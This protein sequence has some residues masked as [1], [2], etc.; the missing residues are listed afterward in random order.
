MLGFCLCLFALSAVAGDNNLVIWDN[1]EAGDKWD[2]AYPVGNGRLGAMP[3]GNFPKEKILLNEETIWHRGAPKVM[4]E[5]SFQHLETVRRLE[6]AGD[7]AGADKSFEK[8]FQQGG[9]NP[10][11]YQP[12]GWLEIEYVTASPLRKRYRELDLK[13][14]IAKNV[15]TL[16]NGS[17]ITQNVFACGSD[18]VIAITIATDGK[19]TIRVRMDG[20]SVTNNQIMVACGGR[21]AVID[22]KAN[23]A[24]AW[25]KNDGWGHS[26][27]LLPDD[28]VA[29]VS[30]GGNNG[31]AAFLFDIKGEAA[32]DPYKQKGKRFQFDMPHGLHWDSGA[33]KL[34]VVDTPGLHLCKAGR[35]KKGELLLEVEKTWA[36]KDLGVIHGHDL[37]PVPCTSQIVMTTHEKVLFFD[38]KKGEWLK[39]KFI[40]RQDVK[41]F[42]PAADGKTFLVSV[43][44]T[45]WWTDT[46][47]I[48]DEKGGFRKLRTF[49]GAK[50]YKARWCPPVSLTETG[51]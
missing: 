44:K 46:L 4:P 40:D 8:T 38:M 39:D 34:Y 33:K 14:G 49:A 29:V 28:I 32:L 42:D 5:D 21:W 51:R 35:N 41:A 2:L 10:D 13:T 47:E 3:F 36:F 20:G 1:A 9:G 15:Y 6:A 19:T 27:E 45:K 18:G 22:R 7:Y 16:E 50:I 23:K 12:F 25:G 48:W 26:I 31:T 30:T 11:S 37:R 17:A 24:V 43:A